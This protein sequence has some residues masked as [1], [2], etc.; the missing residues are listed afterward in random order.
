MGCGALSHLCWLLLL[1]SAAE[2]LRNPPRTRLERRGAIGHIALVLDAFVH[3]FRD[4]MRD[5]VERL[6]AAVRTGTRPSPGPVI[7]GLLRDVARSRRELIAENLLLRQ[8]LVVS[9]RRV[10]KPRFAAHERGLLVALAHFV[11]QWRDAV[12]LVRPETI[13]RW[14][15]AGFRLFWRKKSTVRGRG[16]PTRRTPSET[17]ELIRRLAKENPLWG[18]ERIR[19]ELLKLG[20]HVAKR[21]VQKYMRQ[22][23]GPR[24]WGQSWSTA[25]HH[26]RQRRQVRPRL[27]TGGGGR[28]YPGPP[29]RGEGPSHELV[30]RAVS[31]ERASGVPGPRHRTRR[32]APASRAGGVLLCVL[33]PG[34]ASSGYRS[35]RSNRFVLRRHR[36]RAGHRARRPERASS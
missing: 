30:L 3:R 19:G 8:Q 33:Q 25:V 24:P 21:T 28:R 2:S 5:V 18:A 35:A 36:K 13:L 29:H 32:R 20:V 26:A 34:A 9:A 15:R 6:G 23:R 14:H 16:M 4:A 17:L 12:L 27:R 22:A 11:P 7:S 1:A 10:K 31:G